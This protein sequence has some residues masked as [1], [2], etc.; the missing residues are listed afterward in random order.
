MGNWL[1]FCCCP[2][3]WLA[4]HYYENNNIFVETYFENLHINTTFIYIH[5]VLCRFCQPAD[6]VWGIDILH[7][8]SIMIRSSYWMQYNSGSVPSQLLCNYVNKLISL[9]SFIWSSDYSYITNFTSIFHLLHQQ[10]FIRS[11]S[12]F[13]ELLTNDLLKK[14]CQ[15]CKWNIEL[16]SLRLDKVNNWILIS[17]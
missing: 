11:S 15:C 17:L 14:L 8:S 13:Y 1:I 5:D 10:T 9:V 16:N 4:T 12:A 3:I 7:I 2:P 6:N